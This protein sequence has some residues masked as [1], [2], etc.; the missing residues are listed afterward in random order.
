MI[1][2]IYSENGHEFLFIILQIHRKCLSYTATVYHLQEGYR[3]V[4]CAMCNGILPEN[5]HCALHGTSRSAFR[6]EFNQAAFSQLFDLNPDTGNEVGR[7]KRCRQSEIFD[8]FFQKCRAILCLPGQYY[9]EG[10][11]IAHITSTTS[12]KPFEIITGNDL[13][14]SS[15]VSSGLGPSY[16]E[17]KLPRN[18]TKAEIEVEIFKTCPK[19][20]L[21]SSEYGILSNGSIYIREYNLA[22]SKTSYALQAN[23]RIVICS[24]KATYYT[25]KFGAG[26]GYLTFVGALISVI[27][28]VAHLL[29]SALV[30]ELRNLSGRN[31]ASLSV[32]LFVIYSI[33]IG[34][35]FVRIPSSACTVMGVI[36]YYR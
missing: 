5:L 32:A 27:C 24:P 3:N 8:P 16:E 15:T 17:S 13:D 22:L 12:V 34:M 20:I 21:E 7:V 2:L 31:L 25:D 29:A 26:W 28:I 14:E 9:K 10:E 4:H 30:P 18:K 1:S 33:F 11:C 35:P 19:I 36:L 23:D 6:F